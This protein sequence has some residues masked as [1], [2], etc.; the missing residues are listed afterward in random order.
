[1]KIY[2]SY[3]QFPELS[4]YSAGQKKI[5]WLNLSR[6]A[7]DSDAKSCARFIPAILIAS[8]LLGI[9]FGAFNFR[10]PELGGIVG[11][12]SGVAIPMPFFYLIG[13][14][15]RRP[16]LKR[17]IESDDF[18][19]IPQ[20]HMNLIKRPKDGPAIEPAN[21]KTSVPVRSF[22][23]ARRYD[24]YCSLVGEQRLY[25]NVKLTGIRTFDKITQF[26]SGAL[27]GLLEIEAANATRML[28]P[29]HGIQMICE[30]GAQPTYKVIGRW[31]P[32]DDGDSWRKDSGE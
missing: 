19:L 2:W 3:S 5:I 22:D 20:T 27:C 24:I 14:N 7:A 30:H 31:L 17:Y 13:I 25:Q 21:E 15:T 12:M 18:S 1:M 8:L 26:S 16:I 4:G 10:N 6:W 28:I 9:T 29:Q 32:P 11:A 23:V